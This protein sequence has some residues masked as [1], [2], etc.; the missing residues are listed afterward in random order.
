M[1]SLLL[2]VF[3]LRTVKS[4]TKFKGKDCGSLSVVTDF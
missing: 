3:V 4:K 1:C 2:K